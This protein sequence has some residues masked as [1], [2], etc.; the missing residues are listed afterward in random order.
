MVFRPVPI[1]LVAMLG[2]A[3]AFSQPPSS[4][5]AGNAMLDR[6]K[7]PAQPA[8]DASRPPLSPEMRGDIFM[9]RK[10]YREA[11]DAFGEGPT[12]D[13]VLRNKTGIAYHQLLQLDNARKYYDQAVKL[14]PDYAEAINNLGTVYYAKKSYRRAISYYRRAL[15]LSPEAA[16]IYSNLG[17]ALF[18]R[19]QYPQATEAFQTALK[20]DPDVFEHHSTYGVLLQ[21]RS[22]DERAKFHYYVAKMYAKGGRAELAIQYLRKALEEG[23]KERKKLTEDPEFAELR[24]LPEFK[25]LLTLEPRVL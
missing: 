25:Q 3:L 15:K 5:Q 13:A 9:A 2:V 18:A 17:T 22:V 14:K 6:T 11:I 7:A 16:S 1:G 8:N 23:F 12:Q 4:Q 19:K 10:M 21:E 24:E 20:L